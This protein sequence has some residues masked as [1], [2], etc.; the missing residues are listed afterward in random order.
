MSVIGKKEIKEQEEVHNIALASSEIYDFVI[1]SNES[2]TWIFLLLFSL[3]FLGSCQPPVIFGEPQPADTRSLQKIPEIYQ[4][5]YWCNTDSA[6]LFVDEWAFIKRKEILI[7]LTENEVTE[8]QEL[9]L[10]NGKLFV[11]GWGQSFPIE[12][13]GDTIR[14]SI[15][16]RDTLFAIGTHQVLKPFKGHL[17][18]NKKLD[19]DAWAVLVVSALTPDVLTISKAELPEDLS[20]LQGIT[21]VSTLAKDKD[22]ETQIFITPT[23]AQFELLMDKKLLFQESCTEFE[24]VFPARMPLQ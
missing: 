12:Q 20:Q 11:H 15:V 22:R 6:S 16:M 5:T 17:V 9:Q 23:K 24:R 10:V 2:H 21:P 7:K 8:S 14:S 1:F 18:L 3:M 19:E 4:G 13:N